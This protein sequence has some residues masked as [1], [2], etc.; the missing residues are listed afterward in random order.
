MTGK[1]L[2]KKYSIRERMSDAIETGYTDGELLAYLNDG[3]NLLWH[4]LIQKASPEVLGTLLI[5]D[6][7]SINLPTDYLIAGNDAPIYINDGNVVFYGDVPYTFRYFKKFTALTDLSQSIPSTRSFTNDTFLDLL[8]Q[9]II[10]AAM[11]NHGFDMSAEMD[12]ITS[13]IQMIPEGK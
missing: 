5:N 3:L 13:A 4:T 1:E 9:Y 7:N 11:V 8:A 12:G 2:I 6:K 10:Y